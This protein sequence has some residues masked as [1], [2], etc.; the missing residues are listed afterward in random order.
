M[1]NAKLD[2][3]RNISVITTL[4][5]QKHLIGE[6]IEKYKFSRSN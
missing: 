6:T 2:F 5:N 4:I 1:R 3:V